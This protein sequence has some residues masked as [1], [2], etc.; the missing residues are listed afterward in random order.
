MK[1]NGW[2]DIGGIKR[3]KNEKRARECH[4]QCGSESAMIQ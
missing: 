1:L 4:C 3:N 2:E